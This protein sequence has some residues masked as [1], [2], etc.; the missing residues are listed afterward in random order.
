MRQ[1]GVDGDAELP[2]GR[3][4][5]R[6]D[7]ELAVGED[8]LVGQLADRPVGMLEVVFQQAGDDVV[9]AVGAA[10]LDQ[11]VHDPVDLGAGAGRLLGRDGMGA[12][13]AVGQVAAEGQRVLPLQPDRAGDDIHWQARAQFQVE[14]C[15][16]PALQPAEQRVGRLVDPA[17]LPPVEHAGAQEQRLADGAIGLVLLA[18]HFEDRLADGL[19]APA[20]L[21]HGGGKSQVLAKAALA[22][23]IGEQGPL[24]AL[25]A[26]VMGLVD[27]GQAEQGARAALHHRGAI[28]QGVQ[29]RHIVA[30]VLQPLV[31]VL[32][33][34]VEHL[35][36]AFVLGGE[37]I[38]HGSLLLFAY[39]KSDLYIR[40]VAKL[41]PSQG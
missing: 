30:V 5:A 20:F 33:G 22:G 41:A 6:E 18:D 3:A 34:G 38:G 27:L 11:R 39:A 4:A 14:V 10:V 1:Q 2:P 16:V 31:R 29:L 19:D 15:G 40:I 8:L 32:L 26:D 13:G 37:G 23:G 36:I 24:L 25:G 21:H 35:G 12:E 9:A 17:A 7:D 28:P